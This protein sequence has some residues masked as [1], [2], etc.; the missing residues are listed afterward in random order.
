MLSLDLNDACPRE[1]FVSSADADAA[2]CWAANLRAMAECQ[3]RIVS[4]VQSLPA[5]V[6]WIY[7]R[8]GALTARLADGRWLADCSLPMRAARSM[9]A[10]L[11][12][13]GVTACFLS[14]G[15]A[16][17]IRAALERMAMDQVVIAVVPHVKTLRL[18]LACDDFSDAIAA[19]RLLFTCGDDWPATLDRLFAQRPGLP[20]PAQFIRTPVLKEAEMNE[21]I[22]PAQAVF[23]RHNAERSARVHELIQRPACVSSGTICII[24]PSRFALWNDAGEVLFDAMSRPAHRFDPSN[25]AGASPL[26]L[27]E[28]IARCGSVVSANF[29]RSDVP[30]VAPPHVPWIT[31]ITS[32]R[33]PAPTPGAT[34]DAI[35]LA[36]P[37]WRTQAVQCGWNE[38]QIHVGA[39]PTIAPVAAPTMTI[40]LIADARPIVMPTSESMPL[41]SH[42]LMWEHVAAELADNPL[43]AAGDVDGYLSQCMLKFSITPQG[44]DRPRFIN[45]LI[46]PAYQH[47]LARMMLDAQLP[48]RIY[49][50]GWEQIDHALGAYAGVI[51]NRDELSE[52]ISGSAAVIHPSP[53]DETHPIDASCR[54]IIRPTSAHART[55]IP[56]ALRLLDAGAEPAVRSHPSLSAHLVQNILAK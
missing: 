39:W 47:G 37:R 38:S 11:E 48:L 31:W 51:Q 7:G 9:L 41:S 2:R 40:S 13:I 55:L 42:R 50:R 29:A 23:A 18:I 21:L 27:A 43:A 33:F 49:G 56:M 6:T 5:G 14:P 1:S 54:P 46:V 16:A 32:R 34:K 36:D 35:I 8:D 10:S 20:T 25:G 28:M 19:G 17:Q 53:V 3:P 30:E 4:T 26:A 44:L 15:H 22:S 12:V 45:E 24:A 52:A